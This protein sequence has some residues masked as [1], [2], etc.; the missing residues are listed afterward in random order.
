[1]IKVLIERDIAEG[2]E[3]PYEEVARRVLSAAIQS[4]GFISGESFRDLEH[5]N[6]RVIMVTWQ[7]I[8]SWERWE[9]SEARRD[10]IS[11]FADR[12]SVV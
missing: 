11:K 3:V 1:M 7:N 5:P 2:L 9:E 10:A 6:R 8:R 12:K 4:P